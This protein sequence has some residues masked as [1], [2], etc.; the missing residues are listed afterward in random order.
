MKFTQA[1]V[2]EAIRVFVPDVASNRKAL[3]EAL[4]M[5]AVES[6]L[7][8]GQKYADEKRIAEMVIRTAIK[9]IRET[10]ALTFGNTEWELPGKVGKIK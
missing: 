1:C 10:G 5:A 2:K 9:E 3:P 7:L 6:F 8:N 4:N